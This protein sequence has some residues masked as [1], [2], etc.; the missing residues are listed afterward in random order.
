MSLVDATDATLLVA[1]S[2]LLLA[3]V[4]YRGISI[5]RRQVDMLTRQTIILRTQTDPIP[6][7]QALSFEQNKLHLRIINRG[8][9]AASSLAIDTSVHL[10][11]CVFS[12]DPEGRQPYTMEE[13][14]S[15]PKGTL[16]YPNYHWQP[17]QRLFEEGKGRYPV[18]VANQLLKE[19][20]SALMLLPGEEYDY[21]IDLKFGLGKQRND[22]DYWINYNGLIESMKQ[23]DVWAFSLSLGLLGKNMAE[24]KIQGQEFLANFI[25]DL[26]RHNSLADAYKE[27]RRPYFLGLDMKEVAERIPVSTEMYLHSKSSVNYPKEFE[28]GG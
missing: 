11:K 3:L 12:K 25:V 8:A 10:C 27:N 20:P 16:A 6:I 26:V 19:V 7:V 28:K 2:T 1:I 15:L 24:E 9:G 4:S 21:M 23:N 22:P 13:L 14:K 18:S 5:N 17:K